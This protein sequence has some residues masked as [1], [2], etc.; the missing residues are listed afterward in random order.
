M[1][2]PIP[3]GRG[4]YLV[5]LHHR[6]FVDQSWLSS[7]VAELSD[8]RSRKLEQAWGKP[9]TFS[10]TIN[11]R[12]TQASQLLELATD[13]VVRRWNEASDGDIPIFR[14][15]IDHSEDQLT[16]Q[17]HTINVVCHDYLTMLG[18]RFFTHPQSVTQVDQDDLVAGWVAACKAATATNNTSFSPGSYLPIAVY[19]ANPDGSA[20]AAKSGQ[21]RDRA[22]APSTQY[23]QVL[24]DLSK[25]INGF[26]YDILPATSSQ[27]T[28]S[29]RVFY[30][31]QGVSRPDIV[32]I[33]GTTVASLTRTVDSTAYANYQRV[34]GNNG[35]SDPLAAQL[36]AEYWNADANNVTINP[37]GLWQATDNAS[38]VTIQATLNDKA[39]GDINLSGLL[40]PSYT[41]T[42]RPGFYRWGRPNIG[43]TVGLV[44]RSGRLN[45]N[46]TTRILGI[47]YDINDDGHEDILLTLDRPTRMLADLFTQ[48]DRDVD[49]L[50][51]R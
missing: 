39:H 42:L 8:A 26:D 51:R 25:V 30:P 28:D 47:T 6:H 46:T 22:Y 45:V 32:L 21:L 1:T 29:L 7:M 24:D 35:S 2:T 38:D 13:I 40:V 23:L 31:S 33:Y 11:G 9:A 12:S 18:R 34:L 3:P 14:G 50:T 4:R 17:E 10:F 36:F 37:V 41:V 44:V 48:A 27:L 5:T 15:I 49:A 43:D 20:R 19:Q 16:E